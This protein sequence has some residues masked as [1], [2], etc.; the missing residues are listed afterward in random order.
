ML[1]ISVA[2]FHTIYLFILIVLFLGIITKVLNALFHK[3]IY[4]RMPKRTL[5]DF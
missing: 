5:Q 1:I 3:A 4:S 2:A